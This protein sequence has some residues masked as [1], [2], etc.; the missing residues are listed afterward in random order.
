MIDGGTKSVA[1]YTHINITPEHNFK[2]ICHGCLRHAV[3]LRFLS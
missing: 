3:G 2:A 1:D